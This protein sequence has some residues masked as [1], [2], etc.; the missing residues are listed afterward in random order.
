MNKKIYEWFVQSS[1]VAGG[2]GEFD[3]HFFQF[4]IIQ[5]IKE[6]ALK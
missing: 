5:H 3:G 1:G 6:Y 4:F 2:K